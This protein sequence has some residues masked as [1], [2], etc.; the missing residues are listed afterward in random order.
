VGFFWKLVDGTGK[1]IVKE[2]S[3]VQVLQWKV[4]ERWN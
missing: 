3:A 4:A 2:I 1:G